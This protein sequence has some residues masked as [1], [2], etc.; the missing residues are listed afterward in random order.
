MSIAPDL[1]TAT[2]TPEELAALPEEQCLIIDLRGEAS[3]ALGCISG[4]IAV[5]PDQIREIFSGDVL[6]QKKYVVLYCTYGKISD[7]VLHEIQ[8]MIP[9]GCTFYSLAGGYRAYLVRQVEEDAKNEKRREEIEKSLRKKFRKEIMSPFVQ[10]VNRYELIEPG[11]HIAVCISGG[12]DSMLMAKCFQELKRR[13]KIPFELTFL[14]MDPGYSEDTL[15]MIRSNAKLLGIPLTMF[16][17][18]IFDAVYTIEKSP[19]YLCARM[20]RG[21]LYKKAQDLHCNKIALGHH[22]DDVIETTLLSILYSGQVQTMLPRLKSD[23]FEGM[24]LIRPMYLI[25][26]EA[27]K[28]FRDSNNLRFIRCACRFTNTCAMEKATG[29]TSSKRLEVKRLIAGMKAYN[30]SVEANLFRSME[31]VHLSAILGYKDRDKQYHSFLE[32]LQ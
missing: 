12:K 7:Q 28:H 1:K 14:C 27:V 26:E 8:E 16:S 17:S 5:S 3:H 11:D 30:P 22:Y 9:D 15:E 21:Y 31:N 6:R 18:N 10:A 29:D 24:E 20:R 19:C 2:I 13:N 32:Q 25:R 4:S 23:N